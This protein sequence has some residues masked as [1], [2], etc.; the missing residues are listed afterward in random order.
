MDFIEEVVTYFR[1]FIDRQEA[2][3]LVRIRWE[4]KRAT[5]EARELEEWKRMN[6]L[7]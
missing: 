3:E 6:E 1:G 5:R 7:I 2:K 4:E